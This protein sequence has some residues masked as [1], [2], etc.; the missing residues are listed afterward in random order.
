MDDNPV[1]NGLVEVQW[2]YIYSSAKDY[3]GKKGLVAIEFAY[4]TGQ[5]VPVAN[6]DQEEDIL[7]SQLICTLRPDE[8]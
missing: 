7:I 6:Q 4:K 8:N 5:L 1:R 2:D 3:Q